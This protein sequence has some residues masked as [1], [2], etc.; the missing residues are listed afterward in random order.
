MKYQKTKRKSEEIIPHFFL[1]YIYSCTI[2]ST[3]EKNMKKQM[4]I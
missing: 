2:T 1:P 3:K 4:K